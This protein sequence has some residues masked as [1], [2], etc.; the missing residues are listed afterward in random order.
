MLLLLSLCDFSGLEPAMAVSCMLELLTV[1]PQVSKSEHLAAKRSSSS[2][3]S[4]MALP[5]TNM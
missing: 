1:L 4:S 2:S 3:S 5:G